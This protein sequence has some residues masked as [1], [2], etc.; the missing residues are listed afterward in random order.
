M[1]TAGLGFE[2]VEHPSPSQQNGKQNI[3]DLCRIARGERALPGRRQE[4]PAPEVII[5]EVEKKIFVDRIVVEV[6]EVPVA[7]AAEAETAPELGTA[8]PAAA[9]AR[10]GWP[11]PWLLMTAAAVV[12]AVAA[13]VFVMGRG[14][15]PP[16][17]IPPKKKAKRRARKRPR[18]LR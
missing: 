4:P 11:L 18:R 15:R 12:I 16:R 1:K 2:R 17:R 8:A 13:T 5:V 6:V 14:K 7:R 3:P 9:S 10:A